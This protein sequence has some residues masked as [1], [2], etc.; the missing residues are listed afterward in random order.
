MRVWSKKDFYKL[1]WML[2]GSGLIVVSSGY[3]LVSGFNGGFFQVYISLVGFVSGYKIA[4]IGLHNG[5][6]S[7][8]IFKEY[9]FRIKNYSR[10]DLVSFA[11]GSALMALGFLTLTE[12][13]LQMNPLLAA[14]SAVSMGAGYMIGHWAVNNTLV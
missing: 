5:R 7:K 9:F 2:I 13:I 8:N 14:T 11:G 12:S 1:Y 3:G 6:A 10:I 4:Q